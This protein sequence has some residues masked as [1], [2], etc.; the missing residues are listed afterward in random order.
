MV[1]WGK[2]ED[3]CTWSGDKYYNHL[4]FRITIY[5]FRED[6]RPKCLWDFNNPVPPSPHQ[7]E[8]WVI[9]KISHKRHRY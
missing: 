2:Y 9:R 8:I 4:Q 3:L 5:N 1:L 6:D 7:E